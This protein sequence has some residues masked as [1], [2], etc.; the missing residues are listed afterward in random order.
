MLI[1]ALLIGIV[2]GLRTMMAPAAIAWA[3]TR[4][5]LSL[6]TTWL[7]FLGW[8]YSPWILSLLAAGELVTDQLPSTP[9]R[10]VPV[11]FGARLVSGGI[12][13]MAVGYGGG[14]PLAGLA[15]G[16][17]GAV[18]G[19]LGGAA[20]RE[21]LAAAFGSDRPA[22]LIEDAVAIGGAVLVFAAL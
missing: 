13:G 21:R 18:I 14:S 11:Q 15:L 12:C 19:T 4:G 5:G 9:S 2:A 6:D 10:K 1:L 22:A 7:G 20:V 3:A 8:R 17:V 16:I